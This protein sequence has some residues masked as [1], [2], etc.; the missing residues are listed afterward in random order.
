MNIV[1]LVRLDEVEGK[2]KAITEEMETARKQ[3]KVAKDRFLAKRQE[4]FDLF[5]EAYNHIFGKIDEIYK[6]LTKSPHY[7]MGGNASLSLDN[8]D[9]PFEDGVT[10]HAIPPMKKFR[11]IDQLSGGEQT[12]A[13]L[14]LLFAI[15]NFKP[16]PFFV[17]DEVDSA[18]DNVNVNRVANYIKTIASETF[19]VIQISF[20]SG[21]YEKADA[22]VGIYR[23]T[24]EGSSKVLTLKLAEYD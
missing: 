4:R 16:A 7:P 5:M 17:L 8:P 14:A 21:L 9:E 20:K 23:D 18:L 22:L 19:Q 13:A 3:S 6:D 10:Y 15:N 2:Q 24:D 12:V 11:D 1:I